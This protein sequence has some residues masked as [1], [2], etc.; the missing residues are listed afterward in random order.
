MQNL[1]MPQ[2]LVG[3]A[4]GLF[5]LTWWRGREE[6][7]MGLPAFGRLSQGGQRSSDCGCG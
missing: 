2:V 3:L 1:T 7:E 4:V 6:Q 5:G